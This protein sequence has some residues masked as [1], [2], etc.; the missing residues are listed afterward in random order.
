MTVLGIFSV[1]DNTL[2]FLS[3]LSTKLFP[4]D[5]HDLPV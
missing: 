1:D 4:Y 5:F 2:A 3:L